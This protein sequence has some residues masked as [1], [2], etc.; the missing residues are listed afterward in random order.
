MAAIDRKRRAAF[1]QHITRGS[2]KGS[3]STVIFVRVK[4]KP[5]KLVPLMDVSNQQTQ[6]GVVGFTPGG[7]F[8]LEQRT[9][10][11]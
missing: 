8:G 1:A 4:R 10:Q 9:N 2:K 7:Y 5:E 11:R 6:R 3:R